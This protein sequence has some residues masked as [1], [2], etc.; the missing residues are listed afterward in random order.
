M[1]I[2][3][4]QHAQVIAN[5]LG[6]SDEFSSSCSTL[7]RGDLLQMRTY[8]QSQQISVCHIRRD[9][10]HQS[11]QQHWLV[12]TR[13][14]RNHQA[15]WLRSYKRQ[16]SCH[17]KFHLRISC[18]Q[19]SNIAAGSPAMA[20]IYF[21]EHI[22]RPSSQ[23]AAGNQDSN[24][25]HGMLSILVQWPNMAAKVDIRGATKLEMLLFL[26]AWVLQRHRCWGTVSL[27]SLP[28]SIGRA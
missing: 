28:C 13:P 26:S 8:M 16:P 18:R 22:S 3:C 5:I 4:R 12:R 17:T 9:S 2:M 1:N 27:V 14:A 19:S 20:R 21:L 24:E 23:P 11:I 15:E 25:H 6:C 7:L 10:Y